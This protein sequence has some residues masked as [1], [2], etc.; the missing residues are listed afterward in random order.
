[1]ARKKHKLEEVL[2]RLRRKRDVRVNP[3]NKTVMVLNNKAKNKENDLG[4][5]SWGKI[6]F[7][8][9]VEKYNVFFV[10]EF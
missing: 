7:L 3:G 8:K 5:G 4:N 10:S 1:M 2:F 9:N 6:D